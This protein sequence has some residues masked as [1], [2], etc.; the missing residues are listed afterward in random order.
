[1]ATRKILDLLKD[2]PAVNYFQRFTFLFSVN[3]LLTQRALSFRSGHFGSSR[4]IFVATTRRR[5]LAVKVCNR[6]R[7][8]QSPLAAEA[9]ED[10]RALEH[11]LLCSDRR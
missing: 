11:M 10:T 9:R 3:S 6:L 4:Q 5:S 7:R 2:R 1:M 8:S